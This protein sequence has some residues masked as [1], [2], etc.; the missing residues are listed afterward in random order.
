MVYI[1]QTK[2]LISK[3]KLINLMS[4]KIKVMTERTNGVEIWLHLIIL[5]IHN[6]F[7]QF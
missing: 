4:F 1:L 6:R 3:I 5:G 7:L 2:Q